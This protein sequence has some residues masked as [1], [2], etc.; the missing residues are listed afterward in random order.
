MNLSAM[1]HGL[2]PLDVMPP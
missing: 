2:F 1:I